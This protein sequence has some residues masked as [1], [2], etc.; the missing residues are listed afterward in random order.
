M[1]MQQVQASA[2]IDNTPQAVVGY[3]ADVRNRTYY[4]PSL[5]SLTDV[6]GEPAGVGTTWR[7]TWVLLGVEFTGTG[8]SLAY[9]PGKR[10]SFRT[11]G[12]VEST[13]TYEAAPEGN[14]TRLTIRVEYQLP[15]GVLARLRG[16]AAQARH[17][18]EADHVVANLKTILDR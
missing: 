11:E 3:V 2:F 16:S 6:K 10:Y 15:E 17:Q 18:A 7:W 14:G 1:T 13:W 5:K 9:E 12:G 8:R 4:L